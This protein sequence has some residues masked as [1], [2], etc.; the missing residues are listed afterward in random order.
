MDVS[1]PAA[2]A[3]LKEQAAAFKE[4]GFGPVVI[5]SLKLLL[6]DHDT[7]SERVLEKS[8]QGVG[9]AEIQK[10]EAAVKNIHDAIQSAID[11]YSA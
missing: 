8:D 3:N 7:F 10:G 11:F 9:E 4:S 1:I 2:T 5:A 6:S